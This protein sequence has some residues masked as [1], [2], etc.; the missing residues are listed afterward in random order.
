MW[1]QTL[2]HTRTGSRSTAR[3]IVD[4]AMQA[5]CTGSQAIGG[6]RYTNG[7]NARS[8]LIRATVHKKLTTDCGSC[9]LR[10]DMRVKFI[11][12]CHQR[13]PR[14]RPIALPSLLL[15]AG[16]RTPPGFALVVSAP[17]RRR[18]SRPASR[19]RRQ[20]MRAAGGR[21]GHSWRARPPRAGCSG[22]ASGAAGAGRR[23]SDAPQTN[24]G[25]GGEHDR[26]IAHRIGMVVT[27]VVIEGGA[28]AV[29]VVTETGTKGGRSND[30]GDGVRVG[31]GEG[32]G[33]GG[34]RGG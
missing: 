18:S 8:R 26:G 7:A 25:G 23:P 9:S 11:Y 17:S 24:R 1:F 6:S 13:A 2:R 14:A 32:G 16:E 15:G 30:G 19:H 5:V 33:G 4:V 34:G 12:C 22:C 10:A 20:R 31:D 3:L 27:V 28:E 29:V 21:Q